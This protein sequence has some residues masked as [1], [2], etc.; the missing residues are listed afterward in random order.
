MGHSISGCKKLAQ[1]EYKRRHDN[2]A[3]TV[4]WT[5]CGKYGLQR[6][7][8]WYHVPKGVMESDEI[9]AL[10]DFMIQC[11]HHIECRKSD[12]VVVAKE[13]KMLE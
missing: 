13:E 1:R 7:A 3:R 11:D 6:A 10:R 8:H 2:V 4:H 5:L 9:K 12:I